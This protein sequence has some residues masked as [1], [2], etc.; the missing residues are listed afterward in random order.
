MI[1]FLKKW[2]P[3]IAI[4]LPLLFIY[5]L[6]NC[7]G[8]WFEFDKSLWL[9]FSAVLFCTWNWGRFYGFLSL[10][11]F[12]LFALY[13]YY[14]FNNPN[15][16]LNKGDLI[17][18]VLFVIDGAFVILIIESLQRTKDRA[19]KAYTELKMTE[20]FWR[21]S[22][23]QFRSVFEANMIGLVFIDFKSKIL[24]ANDYFLNMVGWSRS[25]LKENGLFLHAI[26]PPEFLE[27]SLLAMDD[28]KLHGVVT[29]FEKEYFSKNG[30]R[31]P[32]LVG[33]AKMENE[34][35]ATFILDISER[36]RAELDLVDAYS[37]L[38]EHVLLRTQELRTANQEL[39]RLIAASEVAAEELRQSQVFLDSVIENIPSMIFVKGAKDLKYVRFNRASEMILGLAREK[40]IGK[41]DYDLYP[42]EWAEKII[43]QDQKVIEGKVLV[44]LPEETVS[45]DKGLKYIHTRKIPILGIDGEPRYLL[46]IT[47]DITERKVAEAQRLSF[48]Q[49]QAGRREAEKSAERFVFLSAASGALNET[50]NIHPM[51]QGFARVIVNQFADFCCI[52][53]FDRISESIERITVCKDLNKH[54]SVEPIVQMNYGSSHSLSEESSYLLRVSSSEIYTNLSNEILDIKFGKKNIFNKWNN[55]EPKSLMIIPLMTYGK[56]IGVMS[57]LS[58]ETNR[59]YNEVDLSIAQDLAKRTSLAIENATLFRQA[60]EANRTKSAF[61]A[62]ISHEIRTPLGAI[63]GFAEILLSRPNEATDRNVFLATII[64]NAEQLLR[65]VDEILD[66]A[67]V[68]SDHIHLEMIPFSIKKLI[69]DVHTLLSVKAREKKLQLLT[70]F[71]SEIPNQIISDPTRVR[72]ILINIIGNA[73]KFTARGFVRV[74]I[75]LADLSNQTRQLTIVVQDSGIGISSDQRKNLFFPF[76]QADSST[77]R[78]F[79]GTGLGLF[80][81]R[82]LARLLGGDIILKESELNV[83]STFIASLKVTTPQECNVNPTIES[84]GRSFGKNGLIIQQPPKLLESHGPRVLIIDDAKDNRTLVSLYLN[85]LGYSHDSAAT[86]MD[87][88][89]KAITMNFDVLL[90]DIQMPDMDGFEVLKRLRERKYY[91]PIVALTAHA[92]KGDKERCLNAGFD[93]YLRKPL[94]CDS[95]SRCLS[96]FTNK[97]KY[98]NPNMD[99]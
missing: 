24:E 83:G 4:L 85:G 91:K 70:E 9:S 56:V 40:L 28:L 57:L 2:S 90:L 29:P 23:A 79:G 53:L 81:S 35:I 99:L 55:Q 25:D 31:V 67:K 87:G 16:S 59:I 80:L 98:S 74:Q 77:T 11:S 12:I 38:E 50:L 49:E 63:L 51:L 44:D 78:R 13:D 20:E 7:L 36:K 64:R 15:L 17:R 48:L 21:Q 73:I 19:Q 76:S 26:T 75:S 32:V 10:T 39:K 5:V 72:Q 1:T 95:L 89:H 34:L 22:E 62:N 96:Q 52:D 58:I 93:D 37:R 86:G 82:K 3:L 46:G 54:I 71:I 97:R 8:A 69:D 47:E 6:K 92:M 41:C 14:Y 60:Q 30:L 18:G 27:R 45:T 61:L 68:E 42:K 65:I 33:G 94:D 43:A 84:D 88:I 66:L